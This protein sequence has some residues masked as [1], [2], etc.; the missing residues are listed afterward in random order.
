MQAASGPVKPLGRA[1][2]RRSTAQPGNSATLLNTVE[3]TGDAA[4]MAT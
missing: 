3:E 1:R 4:H 2:V